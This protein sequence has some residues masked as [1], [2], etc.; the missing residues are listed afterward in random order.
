MLGPPR[1]KAVPAPAEGKG[2]HC[3]P[4]SGWQ[5]TPCPGPSS[6]GDSKFGDKYCKEDTPECQ[7]ARAW[8]SRREALRVPSLSEAGRGRQPALRVMAAGGPAGRR[9]SRSLRGP[10]VQERCV[11]VTPP[12]WE[13][14]QGLRDTA[15]PHGWRSWMPRRQTAGPNG[16]LRVGRLPFPLSSHPPLEGPWESPEEGGAWPSC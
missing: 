3:L 14:L 10:L 15:R 5:H 2:H 11:L 8:G 4:R 13:Q 7:P 9:G 1:R 16:G 12:R 6:V